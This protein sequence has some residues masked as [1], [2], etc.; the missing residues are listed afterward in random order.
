M[1]AH[2]QTIWH[3]RAMKIHAPLILAVC[4][5]LSGCAT[6]PPLNTASGRPEVTVHGRT[7][8]QV[9]SA[10]TNHFVDYGWT[11]VKTDGNQLVFEH[12]GSAGQAL[13][14]G[15]MTDNPQATNRVTLTLIENG[16]DIRLVGGVAVVGASNFGRSQVVE[17]KGKSLRQMQGAL[18]S[19]KTRAEAH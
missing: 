15:L 9:R 8:A 16:S 18:E 1:L 17:L 10:A 4:L 12:E 19:I 14:M 6:A 3:N 7:A 5:A 13:L 11:P 2:E